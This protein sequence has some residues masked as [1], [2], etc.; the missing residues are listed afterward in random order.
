MQAGASM[1]VLRWS[2]PESGG[3]KVLSPADLEIVAL[4]V[5]APGG[6][7]SMLV[8]PVPPGGVTQGAAWRQVLQN[9]RC[10][11]RSVLC[12]SCR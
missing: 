8:W 1:A 2:N 4:Q 6:L 5:S 10:P 9:M 3:A 12:R 7:Q 11:T